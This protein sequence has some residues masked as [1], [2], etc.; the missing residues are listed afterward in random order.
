MNT[1]KSEIRNYLDLMFMTNERVQRRLLECYAQAC[2]SKDQARIAEAF[3]A[4]R[5][6]AEA[7]GDFQDR[8]II[9]ALG[10]MTF[11]AARGA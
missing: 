9:A 1:E 3:N 8:P 11:G 2:V 4:W 10:M 5:V 6:A 7:N